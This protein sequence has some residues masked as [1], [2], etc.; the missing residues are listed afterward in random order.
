MGLK[1][2][3]EESM[4]ESLW[5]KIPGENIGVD[6]MLAFVPPSQVDLFWICSLLLGTSWESSVC[7]LSTFFY[8]SQLFLYAI[9]VKGNTDH[10]FCS[11]IHSPAGDVLFSPV[12]FHEVGGYFWMQRRER[13]I[14]AYAEDR[15][16]SRVAVKTILSN[17]T[18]ESSNKAEPPSTPFGAFS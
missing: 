12:L 5:V 7:S 14:Q 1:S 17:H 18:F 8:L 9:H 10:P 2:A 16:Q 4:L 13:M 11:D 15:V 3:G 6:G